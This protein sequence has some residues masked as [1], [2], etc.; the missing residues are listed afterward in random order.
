MTTFG[1]IVRVIVAI[2]VVVTLAVA[3][4]LLGLAEFLAAAPEHM[5]LEV[6]KIG[7]ECPTLRADIIAAC[8]DGV[9]SI[10][11]ARQIKQA[12][13]VIRTHNMQTAWK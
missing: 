11:E 8:E 3:A 5:R 9:L 1:A 12:A 4:V 13:Q 6:V 10:A 2:S 7:N